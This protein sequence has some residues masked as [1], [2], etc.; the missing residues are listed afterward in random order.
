MLR[1]SC[2]TRSELRFGSYREFGIAAARGSRRDEKNAIE[3]VFLLREA[4]ALDAIDVDA[5]LIAK[6]PGA[7][8]IS[9]QHAARMRCNEISEAWMRCYVLRYGNGASVVASQRRFFRL[10]QVRFSRP[11]RFR[12]SSES[13]GAETLAALALLSSLSQPVK[14]PA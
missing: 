9:A 8:N 7:T 11:T 6:D 12:A 5:A 10:C 3:F 1:V 2:A 4:A 13:H 14:P